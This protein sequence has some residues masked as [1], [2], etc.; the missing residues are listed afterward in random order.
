MTL[1]QNEATK[2]KVKQLTEINRDFSADSFINAL[3]MT[4]IFKKI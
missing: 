2:T 4:R 1:T 3:D